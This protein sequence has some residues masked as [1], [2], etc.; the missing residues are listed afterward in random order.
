MNAMFGD[1]FYRRYMYILYISENLNRH[2]F[3]TFP[4]GHILYTEYPFGSVVK[5]N[6]AQR[7]CFH[8]NNRLND[9]LNK[10]PR[11]WGKGL[12]VSELNVKHIS[13]Q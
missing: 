1:Q 8:L 3:Y 5:Q 4:L 6:Q 10:K 13:A 12:L 7:S 2:L 9:L 11:K